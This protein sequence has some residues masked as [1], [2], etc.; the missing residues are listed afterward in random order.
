MSESNLDFRFHI[1]VN[2]IQINYNGINE[3][4]LQNM[5]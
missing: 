5:E 2:A 1:I 3:T 4:P